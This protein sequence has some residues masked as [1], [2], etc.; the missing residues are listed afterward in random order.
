MG[1]HRQ[2]IYGL[3]SACVLMA[4]LTGCATYEKCGI[5]GCPGDARITQNVQTLFDKHP[6][7]GP[8]NLI[9]IQTLDKVVYLNGMAASGLERRE[10]ESVAQEAPGVTRIVNLISVTH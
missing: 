10:A 2:G 7:L 3:V 9:D 5:E 8:P 4:T 1:I 6:D